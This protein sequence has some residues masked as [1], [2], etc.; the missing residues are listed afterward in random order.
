MKYALALA[1]LFCFLSL[2]PLGFRYRLTCIY[3]LFCIPATLAFRAESAWLH[4]W[5]PWI[6]GP[7]VFLRLASGVE[8][9]HRQTEGFRYW[10]RLM[11]S[12]FLVA[13]FFAGAGW[14]RSSHPDALQA[15]VEVR[16]LFQIWLG[17]VF[18]TSQAFWI[19]QGGGWYRR[20]DHVAAL[21]GVLA[22]NHGVVSFLSGLQGWGNWPGASWW[23][24]GIDAAVYLVMGLRIRLVPSWRLNPE[25][26]P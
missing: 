19:S 7:V 17:G 13:G 16:R 11:G 14:V 10:W 1:Q 3:L 23:S 5:Y 15:M 25:A 6:A 26:R 22:L 18:L 2:F 24:W 20:S 4:S 12:V 21:F 8:V 9:L